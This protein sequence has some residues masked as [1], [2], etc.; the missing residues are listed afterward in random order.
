MVIA[1]E[2][3]GRASI[4]VDM[5]GKGNVV[6]SPIGE[7][8]T[9]ISGDTVVEMIKGNMGGAVDDPVGGMCA[10]ITRDTVVGMIDGWGS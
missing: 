2:G 6:G 1:S 10:P 7:V 8:C 4:M 9:P 3:Q 5:P